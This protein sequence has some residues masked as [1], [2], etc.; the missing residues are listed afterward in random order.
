MLTKKYLFL[1]VASLLLAG[2]A[3]AQDSTRS[4]V[5]IREAGDI[6][7]LT[8]NS[9]MAIR[10]QLEQTGLDVSGIN[11]RPY[12]GSISFVRDYKKSLSEIRFLHV[13]AGHEA[14]K[15]NVPGKQATFYGYGF[16]FT[17]TH[18]VVYTRR[19]II[20]PTL[21]YDFMWYRLRLLP[22]LSATSCPTPLPTT[23][24]FSGRASI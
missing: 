12:V 1:L 4:R 14:A 7:L 6:G 20:G 19:F 16:G 23:P 3:Q 17:A 18:K 21:G 15:A 13:V 5:G 10:Q 24:S 9:L 11:N 2:S 8:N 22:Q